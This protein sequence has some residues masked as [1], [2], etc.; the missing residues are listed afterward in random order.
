MSSQ[1]PRRQP[2]VAISYKAF[3]MW[4]MDQNKNHR[5]FDYISDADQIRGYGRGTKVALIGAFYRNDHWKDINYRIVV[6]DL[7]VE[8]HDY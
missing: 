6:Q 3:R 1:P 7:E 2:A 8:Y 4:C 5:A